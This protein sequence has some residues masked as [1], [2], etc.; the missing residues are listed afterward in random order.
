M[1]H[2]LPK[3]LIH[4]RGFFCVVVIGIGGNSNVTKRIY[5]FSC[6]KVKNKYSDLVAF[7]KAENDGVF[8]PPEG[9]QPGW[10]HGSFY[11]ENY[12]LPITQE[13]DYDHPVVPRRNLLSLKHDHYVD[14]L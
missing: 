6:L 9:L 11:V 10:L 7:G 3:P 12:K 2:Q 4:V 1:M 13:V 8:M 5:A 14:N